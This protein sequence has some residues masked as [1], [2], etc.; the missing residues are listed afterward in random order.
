MKS[1]V[2]T[3][4]RIFFWLSGAGT[5]TLESCPNWE[6]RKYVAFGATVLVPCTFAFIACA[7]ALSTISDNN[8]VI[9]PVASV[10]AAII[11]TIDRALLAAYRPYLSISR[12]SGQFMLRF[13]VAM[14]MGVTIAHPL[15]L[16]LFSDTVVT[17]I[18]KQRAAEIEIARM[19]FEK[20]KIK[21]QDQIA[22]VEK[23]I[24]QQRQAW[25]DSYQAK[26]ILQELEEAGPSL[27]SLSKEQQE[28]LDRAIAEATAP[29]T[30]RLTEVEKQIAEI[31]PSYNETTDALQY[32][33]A[34]FER[35]INGERSGI[36]GEGPRARSILADQLEP[37]REKSK[38]LGSLLEDLTSLKQSLEASISQ[39][40]AEALAT[41]KAKMAEINARNQEEATRVAALVHKIEEDQAASFVA[42]QNAMRSTITMQIDA[43][44]AE[45]ERRQDGLARLVSEE[46]TRLNAIRAEPRRDILTQTL[47]LH[48]LFSNNDEGG[49]FALYTYGIL[50]LL[51]MLVDTIPLVI[52]FFTKP[53]PYDNL[54]DRDEV[55]FASERQAFLTAHGKYMDQL[56]SSN[57]IA[58]TRDKRLESILVDGV[59]H[60]RAANEF[61]ES[62]IEMEKNFA[63]KMQLEQ[64]AAANGDPEKIAAL[65][66]MKKRFY[67]NL[68]NRMESFFAKQ[69]A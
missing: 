42:Q 2:T 52:K 41:A 8:A 25:A 39:A 10:W 57:L 30:K 18:E 56:A 55:I 9:Y 33:Q 43:R 31:L 49:R 48:S 67:D 62:L 28:K 61:L 38:R 1:K 16:L 40:E 51:F 36:A 3:A 66:A 19:A 60:S 47:A 21:V 53:G 54:L 4:K 14:L 13:F 11:L 6:Q 64:E 46:E 45:L 63:Q 35:E 29:Y 27:A 26:F 37:R 20:E 59:E 65:E 32:W 5:E 24:T 15:V 69:T 17:V 34:E 58:V 23:G 68:H 50:V 22:K 12:K 7:Y 44:L